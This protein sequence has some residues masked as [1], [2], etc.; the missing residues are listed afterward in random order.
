[1]AKINSIAWLKFIKKDANF[2]IAVILSILSGISS[3]IFAIV[4]KLVMDTI[5]DKLYNFKGTVI[6]SVLLLALLLIIKFLKNFFI[7]TVIK[8]TNIKN[9]NIILSNAIRNY[10]YQNNY[11]SILT[12]DMNGIET[13]YMKN[14]FSIITAICTFT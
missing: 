4:V 12:N 10:N 8:R 9:K 6:I 14:L 13:E 5:T 7:S 2:Y 1:M 11:V 3:I